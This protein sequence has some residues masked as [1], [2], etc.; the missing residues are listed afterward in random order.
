MQN[1]DG[2]LDSIAGLPSSSLWNKTLA[3]VVVS[4]LRTWG[5]MKVDYD[6]ES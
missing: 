3:G 2:L 5:T 1:F 4:V 6:L